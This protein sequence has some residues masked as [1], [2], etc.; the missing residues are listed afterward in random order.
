MIGHNIRFHG[1]ISI[2][3]LII[4]YPFLTEQANDLKSLVYISALQKLMS[5]YINAVAV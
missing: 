4:P 5:K 2:Y 3:F 1:D